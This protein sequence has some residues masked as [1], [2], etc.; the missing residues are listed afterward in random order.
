MVVLA[1]KLPIGELISEHFANLYFV[2]QAIVTAVDRDSEV[3]NF[4]D[5]MLAGLVVLAVA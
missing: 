1:P 2:L 3:R 4:S 5:L